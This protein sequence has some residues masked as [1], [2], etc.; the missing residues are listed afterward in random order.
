MKI[1]GSS[2]SV[3]WNWHQLKVCSW[4]K[5]VGQLFTRHRIYTGCDD[6]SVSPRND[7]GHH[8]IVFR[9]TEYNFVTL[10]LISWNKK[11]FSGRNC[12]TIII[13]WNFYFNFVKYKVIKW[14]K[15][16]FVPRNCISWNWLS[17]RG[18]NT[19]SWHEIL[20]S[21]NLLSFREIKCHFVDYIVISWTK[22]AIL[23]TKL[24]FR[25]RNMCILHLAPRTKLCIKGYK[26]HKH[27]FL[28][29]KRDNMYE[30]LMLAISM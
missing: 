25:G 6:V 28:V 24:S 23:W 17:F 3:Y 19:I 18:R 22:N 7:I 8:G 27:Y 4:P 16:N 15:Y 14:T 2:W 29:D 9:G 5:N 20:I 11:L 10:I 21:W 30:I 13:K 1:K 26:I 12:H